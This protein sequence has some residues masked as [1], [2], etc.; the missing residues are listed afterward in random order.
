MSLTPNGITT[1]S[2][3]FGLLA[4]YALYKGWIWVFIVSYVISYFFDC[5]DGHYARKYNQVT[6]FGDL[7]DHAKDIIVFI[8]ICV[9]LYRRNKYC[10]VSTSVCILSI[11]GILIFLSCMHLGC[12]ECL[13]KPDE[14]KS[15]ESLKCLCPGDPKESI[16][17]TRYFGTATLTIAFV[18]IIA[19]IEFSRICKK[20]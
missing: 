9:V 13:Y 1:I 17:T 6:D 16:T 3:I 12:Q 19:F 11:L 20:K 15:L 4:I 18:C 7:Y 2:L 8:G 10:S 14:S 5:T